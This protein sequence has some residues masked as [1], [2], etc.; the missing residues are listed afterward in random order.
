MATEAPEYPPP[1]VTADVNITL[2]VAL[3]CGSIGFLAIVA[4]IT[5]RCLAERREK[6]IKEREKEF[7]DIELGVLHSVHPHIPWNAPNRSTDEIKTRNITWKDQLR[8][9]RRKQEQRESDLHTVLEEPITLPMPRF[10]ADITEAREL[11]RR[12]DSDSGLPKH[13]SSRSR[14]GHTQ[15]AQALPIIRVPNNLRPVEVRAGIDHIPR[16]AAVFDA[17][18]E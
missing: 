7:S 13:H 1:A 15:Q 5:I 11:L 10:E 17:R 18:L 9:Y 4:F 8:Y 2:V 14:V 16:R 12:K 3:V 6:Q